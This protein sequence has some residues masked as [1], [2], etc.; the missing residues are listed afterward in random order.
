M[1]TDAIDNALE[2][3]ELPV[4]DMVKVDI[5]GAEILALNGMRKLLASDRAPKAVF[6][7]VHPVF[8]PHFAS[9]PEQVLDL[10]F[11]FGYRLDYRSDCHDQSHCIFLRGDK[12]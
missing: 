10:M 6:M 4:P 12:R 11:S 9:S 8:L 5:E 3:G 2:R 1:R 7:E